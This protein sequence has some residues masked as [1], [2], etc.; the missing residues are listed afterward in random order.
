[1]K[2]IIIDGT[3]GHEN[4]NGLI[5]IEHEFTS[6]KTDESELNYANEFEP[7]NSQSLTEFQPGPLSLAIPFSLRCDMIGREKKNKE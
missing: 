2:G 6:D 3:D 4:A 7:K 1:M 5:R